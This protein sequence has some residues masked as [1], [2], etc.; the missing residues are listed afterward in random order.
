MKYK[1]ISF[2]IIA[3]FFSKVY[4]QEKQPRPDTD[5]TD[6]IRK[7]PN[8]QRKLIDGSTLT[9]LDFQTPRIHE[10]HQ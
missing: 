4:D 6:A 8:E 3:V 1:L 7:A 10:Y 5:R 9:T 2:V